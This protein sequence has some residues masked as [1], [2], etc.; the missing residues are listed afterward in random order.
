[1]AWAFAGFAMLGLLFTQQVWADTRDITRALAPI[2]TTFVLVL[3][4]PIENSNVDVGRAPEA[5]SS[6][7]R[8]SGVV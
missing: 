8:S 1:V 5:E 6:R 3:I 7:N 4:A 2:L